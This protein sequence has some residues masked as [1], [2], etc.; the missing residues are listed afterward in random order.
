[1]NLALHLHSHQPFFFNT[2][3]LGL[4]CFIKTCK[5]FCAIIFSKSVVFSC[6]LAYRNMPTIDSSTTKLLQLGWIFSHCKSILLC[7][8]YA[9]WH[10]PRIWPCTFTLGFY[11]GALIQKKG[12]PPVRKF[13]TEHKK[14]ITAN[15]LYQP[16]CQQKC[17]QLIFP[18]G[19]LA[20]RLSR[21]WSRHSE[22]SDRDVFCLHPTTM[23]F[24]SWRQC[25]VKNNFCALEVFLS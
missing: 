12:N 17:T 10:Q 1:M 3:D 23:V 9:S 5:P 19:G 15:L 24:L 2:L 13:S 16:K 22:I 20:T 7:W 14:L 11:R 8:D 18:K 21:F 6:P 4:W 25:S